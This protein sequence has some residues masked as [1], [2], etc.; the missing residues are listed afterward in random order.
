MSGEQRHLAEEWI[1]NQTLYKGKQVVRHS[2]RLVA[3]VIAASTF[4][5]TLTSALVASI[6]I[7]FIGK[8]RVAVDALSVGA[9]VI[10]IER[11]TRGYSDI[12]PRA[13]DVAIGARPAEVR[14]RARIAMAGG[15]VG[16]ADA[17]VIEGGA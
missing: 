17:A 14:A 10:D 7:G 6:A 9:L 16:V 13:G 5:P 2:T 4:A 8:G 1:L 15:T 3:I 12:C 11:M